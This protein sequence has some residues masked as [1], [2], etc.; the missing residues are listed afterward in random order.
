MSER[1]WIGPGHREIEVRLFGG[2]S[3]C[4]QALRGHRFA[5]GAE[6]G[7]FAR[8][9]IFQIEVAVTATIEAERLRHT[10]FPC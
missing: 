6:T 4:R 2:L 10:I 7:L 9:D 5:F 1:A 8:G 3:A